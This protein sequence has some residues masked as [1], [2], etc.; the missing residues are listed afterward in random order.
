MGMCV[1]V[2][3]NMAT[4]CEWEHVHRC[5][6][7]QMGARCITVHAELCICVTLGAAEGVCGA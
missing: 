6:C 5:G 3:A 2:W 1:W 7:M 4:S